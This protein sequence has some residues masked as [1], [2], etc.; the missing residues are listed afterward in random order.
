MKLLAVKIYDTL[1][2]VDIQSIARNGYHSLYER[3]VAF[4]VNHYDISVFTVL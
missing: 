1:F 2:K 3:N 4:S